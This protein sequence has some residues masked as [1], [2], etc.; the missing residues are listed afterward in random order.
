MFFSSCKEHAE[1]FVTVLQPIGCSCCLLPELNTLRHYNIRE[2]LSNQYWE[3]T[4]FSFEVVNKYRG[5][6]TLSKWHWLSVP[7]IQECVSHPSLS[8]L[9][10]QTFN[11]WFIRR[12]V[13]IGYTLQLRKIQ[14]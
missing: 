14:S 13:P 7:G 12:E 6:N 3:E 2:A 8:R 11:V 9:F 1:I 4:A 10:P 5:S